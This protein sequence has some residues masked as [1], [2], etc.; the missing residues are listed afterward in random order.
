MNPGFIIAAA[1]VVSAGLSGYAGFVLAKNES[2]LPEKLISPES[3]VTI[4]TP[5]P[6]L[7]ITELK[8]P[9]LGLKSTIAAILEGSSGTYAVYVKNLSTGESFTQNE[10]RQFA[11]ASLYKLWVMA[12]TF[13][14]IKSGE[15]SPEETLS[16]SISDLNSAFNIA[17]DQAEL[18]TGSISL[19][20]SQALTQMITISHNYAA[21]LLAK[22]IGLPNIQTF[23][24]QNK[25]TKTAIGDGSLTTAQDVGNFLEKIY[26]GKLIDLNS[27]SAML[28]LLKD[29]TLNTKL[30]KYLPFG[31]IVAHKTG[32]LDDVTHDAGIVY[33]P[34]GDYILVVLTQ[35]DSP[36]DAE[37]RIS[38][39][40]QA[41][42]KYFNP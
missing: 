35:S 21:L 38:K 11:A 4:L 13:D 22:K 5:T 8:N 7:R 6:T 24:D 18:T 39:I 28:S 3:E 29:Q 32:E 26:K 27:S 25:F 31:T 1:I 14:Q 34:D 15:L 9:S 33:S 16:S 23:I 40:S 17:P 36:P 37:E 42:Y 19:T 10:D 12:E 20:V 30:P 41:V 2:A